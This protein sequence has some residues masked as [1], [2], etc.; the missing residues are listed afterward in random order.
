M[1]AAASA[2]ASPR[3]R[4]RDVLG[5]LRPFLLALVFGLACFALLFHAE[6][7]AAVRV[8]FDSTAYS[9]CFLVLPIALWLA[10][11]RREAARGLRPEP[12]V[13]PAL[14]VIPF[15]LAWFAA[16]RLGIMEGRQLAVLGMLEA[17]LVALL[18][19]R[20]ARAQAP[21]LI[22]LVFLV[23]V[24]S[25][26]VPA[27]QN[28]T[29]VFTEV[30][31]EVL[32]IPH[33]VDAFSIE[34]PEGMFYVA[35]AC[36][37]L[38]FLIAAIAFGVLYGF[39]TY[40]SLWRR[41]A[42][43]AASIIVPIIANGFRA[44][45]IVVAGH[46]V[47]DAQA[48]AA[49]HLIYGWV[50]FSVVIVLLALA[51]LPFREDARPAA[52]GSAPPTGATAGKAPA[53]I[54]QAIWI[55][56]LAALLAA[57][58]PAASSALNRPRAVPALRLP[59]FA[60]T[61]DCVSLGDPPGAEQKFSCHGIPLVASLRVLPPH[62]APATLRAARADAT[63]Q[64][65]AGDGVT[66]TLQVEGPRPRSWRVLELQEPTRITASDMWIAGAPVPDGISGRLKLAWD[67]ITGGD[68]PAVLVAAALYPP[69]LV[70]SD[71]RQAARL[72]LR[73][74]LAAQGPLLAAVA[75]ATRR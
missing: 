35:E 28:F 51:G 15:G 20:L 24:G 37:G 11:D 18:G 31:L 26:L 74:F 70:H 66:S 69:P 12:T 55:A 8:W 72:V 33:Y 41:L 30:G 17:L 50:F 29:A 1:T 73:D 39:L 52:A 42:F 38:R 46:I 36:A 61:A 47:G 25:F 45:G 65:D 75:D 63:G 2:V 48:A 19:W 40:R 32:G 3:S 14:A 60:A 54:G 49:D 53:G 7:A 62:A 58:G 21:A 71:Q 23:P 44:L 68:A 59:G 57:A 22:Y 56:G 64:H 34:I 16:E 43:L 13:W 10:W 27:L 5:E 67:S 6:A 4:W 9:H